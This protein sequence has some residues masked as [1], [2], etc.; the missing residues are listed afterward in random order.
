MILNYFLI[1]FNAANQPV[2]SPLEPNFK[3]VDLKECTLFFQTRISLINANV[4][5]KI[6]KAFV[7]LA[8]IGVYSRRKIKHALAPAL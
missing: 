5:Q 4:S 7:G 3:M 6:S 2:F 8:E 1:Q